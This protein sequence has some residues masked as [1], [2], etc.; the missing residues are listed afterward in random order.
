MRSS[1]LKR[2]V[3]SGGTLAVAL[4]GMAV[5]TAAPASAKP[6]IVDY[7]FHTFAYG[8]RVQSNT[9]A[10]NTG[11]S[12]HAWIACTRYAGLNGD[13]RSNAA[14][15][16]AAADAPQSN[17]LVKLGAMET[18]NKTFRNKDKKI[19]GTRSISKIASVTLKGPDQGDVPGPVF[20]LEG[21]TTMSKVI[22][23]KGVFDA[24]TNIKSAELTLDLPTGTPIDEPLQELLDALS[25]GLG[26]VID[27]V[28]QA[29]GN[30][31][32]I[33]G[34]GVV[35]P[36]EEKTKI[37][38]RIA[39]ASAHGLLVRL[40]GQD[41]ARGTDDDST[42]SIG[43]SRARMLRDL[44]S[45]VMNGY[46]YG[47]DVSAADGLLKIG[48]TG[49]QPLPCQGT[50]GKPQEA[51][52][53]PAEDLLD[54]VLDVGAIKGIVN[55]LQNPDGTGWA[56][57]RGDVS[58]VTVGSGDQMV[59][60]VGIVGKANVK[61]KASGKVVRNI[62]GTG[63]GSITVG[64]ET[65]SGDE[66]PTDPIVI[67]GLGKIEFNI[68]NMTKRGVKVTAVRITLNPGAASETVINL[69]NARAFLKPA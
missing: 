12:A 49:I 30:E 26:T 8:T 63:I 58:R 68:K 56:W 37:G 47:L 44:P 19:V 50:G 24:D 54:G 62:N 48:E 51:S 67:D 53:S 36:G 16:L 45:G 28:Q 21:I 10:L 23:K 18:D 55:G 29:A 60:I 61:K 11:R 64:G 6:V 17:P 69:G 40:Y 52:A 7:G 9:V 43:R 33:P 1:I 39:T 66:V 34:L 32:E 31:I 22:A 3:A 57:T 38:S 25:G 14:N 59:E 5:L 15:F 41:G 42:I 20:R 27:T 2:L 4:A 65:V 13:N 46:G 35:M